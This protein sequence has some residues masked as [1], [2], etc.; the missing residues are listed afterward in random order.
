M[1]KYGY[2]QY[3]PGTKYGEVD[4]NRLY[5][6]SGISAWA[7][8]YNA[9]SLTWSSIVPDPEDASHL[10]THWRLVRNYG[11]EADSPFV[12]DLLDYDVITN[13]RL[14]YLDTDANIL[15]NVEATYTL[16]IFNG[17]RWINTGSVAVQIVDETNTSTALKRWMPAA[18]LND[19]NGIG[20]ATGTAEDTNLS[21]IIDAYAFEYDKLKT[22]AQLIEDSSSGDLIPSALLKDKVTELGFIYEPALG[23]VYHRSLYKAG[24]IIN[25]Y[26]G[27]KDGVIAYT[28]A[29]TH[30]PSY[31]E[32]GNNLFLDYNDSSFEES[33]GRW[34]IVGG[35]LLVQKYA[36]ATADL[37]VVI[38]PAL[39]KLYN[40]NYPPRS[41]GCGLI[42]T[43]AT[44]TTLSLPATNPIAYGI[45]VKAGTRY[46]V[47]G[48]V[49]QVTANSAT[50]GMTISWFNRSGVLI[51]E[52]T[53]DTLLTTTTS[54][55]E[56]KSGSTY[57]LN[58]FEAPTNSVYAKVNIYFTAA[59]GKKFLIDMLSFKEAIVEEMGI[60]GT[61]PA[62]EYV[63]SRLV[64]I[65]VESDIENVI[66]NPEF[67]NGTSFWEGYNGQLTVDATAP[68]GTHMM[69]SLVGKLTATSEGT[70]GIVSDWMT[71]YSG[72]PYSFSMYISGP[73]GRTA[74]A[75]LEFSSQ[76]TSD[77]QTGV[78]LDEET[79]NYYYPQTP[80]YVDSADFMVMPMA[81]RIEVSIN[82]PEYSYEFGDPMGKV[83]I[84]ITDAQIGD[85]FYF[86]CAMLSPTSDQKDYF[87][88]N[89][90]MDPADPNINLFFDP[91]DCRWEARNVLNFVSNTTFTNTT[92]WTAGTGS[93]LTS[94][95][96]YSLYGTTS[97]KVSKA[98]GGSISTVV[99]LPRGAAIGG[100]DIIVSA[101]VKNKAGTYTISTNGQ[102][103]NTHIVS[104]AA[105]D[106]WTKIH[107]PRIT[108]IGETTFT[109]TISLNTGNASAAVFY[110]DGVQAEYGRIPTPFVNPADIGTTTDVNPADPSKNIYYAYKSLNNSGVSYWSNR[111]QTKLARLSS[112]I[113]KYLP[114]GSSH[115]FG[116]P[117][118]PV[119]LSDVKTTLLD[120]ASF[121][122]N[123]QGWNP[124]A[125]TIKRVS[126]RG[127]LFDDL[128]THGAAYAKI[129][130]TSSNVFGATTDLI[131]VSAN[132]GY[133][134]SAAIRPENEDAFGTYTL[135]LNWYDSDKAVLF[136]KITTASLN[137]N[138]RWHHLQ[139]VAP[140]SKTIN[141][142]LLSITN[143]VV[144][145]TTPAPH[146]FSIGEVVTFATITGTSG[147]FHAVL[148][149]LTVLITGVTSNTFTFDY[150]YADVADSE[151][152]TSVVFIN[153]GV[154]YASVQVVASPQFPGTGRTFHL[155]RVMFRE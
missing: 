118:T 50:V 150:D 97:G 35:T 65:L 76:A 77:A 133:Y 14:S 139:V 63:D 129:A 134:L 45:P 54:W 23:D 138:D 46:L 69:N 79:G 152:D 155:D 116:T 151:V 154:A 110:V 55:Q 2:F 17:V 49:R 86:S 6:S 105:K 16:W 11:G 58:G 140:G 36:T 3:G 144:T 145:A 25:A 44:T 73:E 8:D 13:Y 89:G 51:S 31:L 15:G 24:H 68:E 1:G 12:G 147:L 135:K 43:S 87:S 113:S 29:M 18:W 62:Y 39:P 42:T 57:A 100:E 121:E 142:N 37:G 5:Y 92:G 132:T 107:V 130:S 104:E 47:T 83:T 153:T 143:N 99:T 96:D 122:A 27:S 30:W 38:T 101:Y 85:V 10:P 67:E 131:P 141:V 21:K 98:G 91:V 114:L 102:T 59:S 75:R 117:P 103:S 26:K 7:Y 112:T 115:E 93:T 109:V 32:Y 61:V 88:G 19:I 106:L 74:K 146:N 81:D 4:S 53:P 128:L 22:Q 125:A 56:F 60:L 41:I 124:N 70:V 80:Y 72:N 28:T 126:S 78:L 66:F 95:T 9:V 137:K 90:G 149:S 40:L 82:S 52:T 127:S 108:N 119:G 20:D 33:I 120:S 71:L 94:S 34:S 111:Y 123:L 84:Y 64:E 136:S 48:L 148:S